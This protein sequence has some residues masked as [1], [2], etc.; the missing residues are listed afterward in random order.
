MISFHDVT[1]GYTAEKKFFDRLSVTIN[2]GQKVGI[3][4]YSGSGKTTFV[5]LLLRFFD[6]QSGSITIDGQNIAQVTQE[7][8]RNSIIFLPQEPILFRRSLR[9]NICYC[10]EVITEHAMY[11]AAKQAGIHELIMALPKG[12]DT[13]IGS[14]NIHLSLGQR[15]RIMFARAFLKNTPIVIMDEATSALDSVAEQEI[16]RST[17]L[18]TSGKTTLIIAHRLSTLLTMDR[19]LV[20]DGGMIVEDGTHA[21]LLA[22]KGHYYHL[23]NSQTCIVSQI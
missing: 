5:H 6:I 14:D 3:V 11:N 2:S 1:F 18:L 15:Q 19:I 10:C 20:F 16:H 12:Y 13:I 4:G 23:W 22:R 8:L 17:Q 21:E 9:E 7:S